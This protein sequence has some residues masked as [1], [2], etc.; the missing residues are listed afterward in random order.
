MFIHKSEDVRLRPNIT[1]STICADYI[2]DFTCSADANP[3]VKRYTLFKNDSVVN[4]STLGVWSITMNTARKFVHRCEEAFP[5]LI[6]TS[7]KTQKVATE[8]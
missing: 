1:N 6:P 3:A 5:G 2:V 7:D 4:T 8:C